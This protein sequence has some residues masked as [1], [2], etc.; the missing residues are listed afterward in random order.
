MADVR[1]MCI[2][3]PNPQSPHEHITHVGGSGWL[4]TREEVI[5]S[6]DAGTNS[7]YVADD[8]THRRSEVG[9][10]RSAGHP[11]YLR[12]YADGVWNDNLLALPQCPR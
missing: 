9:V 5:L 12:T 7:F 3:K 2:I 11:A 4:W 10:V 8:R 1:V 6:I